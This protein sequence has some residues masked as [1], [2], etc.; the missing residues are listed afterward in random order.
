MQRCS[1]TKCNRNYLRL[2]DS[3]ELKFLFWDEQNLS[4]FKV[5]RLMGRDVL[6]NEYEEFA[7]KK[8]IKDLQNVGQKLKYCAMDGFFEPH[9]KTLVVPIRKDGI[10]D[11]DL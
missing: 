10:R 11:F 4:R 7:R 6:S 3:N 8:E 1:F 5:V 2:K 9:E